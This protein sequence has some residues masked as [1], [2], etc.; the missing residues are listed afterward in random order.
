MLIR[1]LTIQNH[2]IPSLF[3]RQVTFRSRLQVELAGSVL[4]F[5]WGLGDE[6]NCLVK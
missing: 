5:I 2:Y 1:I 3:I 4:W 6:A